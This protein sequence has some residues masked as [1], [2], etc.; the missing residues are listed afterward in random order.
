VSPTVGRV[1][2]SAAE[3]AVDAIAAAVAA[4]FTF[5]AS[6]IAFAA[7]VA[8]NVVCLALAAAATVEAAV[9]HIVVS[10]L[11]NSIFYAVGISG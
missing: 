3:I 8:A 9:N 2:L 6:E 1:C 10:P 11:C 4:W 7:E 5:G